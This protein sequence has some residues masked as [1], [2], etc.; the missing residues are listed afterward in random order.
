LTEPSQSSHSEAI[1]GVRVKRFLTLTVLKLSEEI[2]RRSKSEETAKSLER[3]IIDLVK[4]SFVLSASDNPTAQAKLFLASLGFSPCEIEWLED[5]R[6][7]KILLGKSRLWKASNDFEANL[8]K[9]LLTS[10][11]KGIGYSFIDANVE[12]SFIEGEL[13]PPRFSY[14]IQFR[15]AEDVFAESFQIKKE[16]QAEVTL[17]A[18]TL[19]EPIL[20]TGV[21]VQ[22]AIQFLIEGTHIVV[23]KNRPELLQRTGIE[24]YPLKLLEVFFIEVQEDP[25]AEMFAREIGTYMVKELRSAL[26][27]LKNH[28]ILKGIGLLPPEQIDELLFY[29]PSDICGTENQGKKFE[30]C[31]FL[32]HIWAGFSSEVL[33]KPFRMTEDPLCAG[34][35]SNCIFTFEEVKPK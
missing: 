22:S 3:N 6:L 1:A 29:A 2:L 31:K 15:A 16:D 33:E 25:F 14:E 28:Q 18:N 32:G 24:A 5:V 13:L 23:E 10:I 4:S 21:R 30:F 7:G 19:L 20:G 11:V 27:D 9:L 8:I 35:G 34:K 12:V 17:P 26:P